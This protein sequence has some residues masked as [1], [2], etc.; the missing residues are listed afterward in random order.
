MAGSEDTSDTMRKVAMMPAL[1]DREKALRDVFVSEYLKDFDPLAAAMRCGFMRSFAEEYA[2]KFMDEPY[3]LQRI[4]ALQHIV[5][6]D[7]SGRD[8]S[9]AYNRQRVISALMREA[10][11]T[12][13]GSSAA[14][15]VAALS[16]LAV[17]YGL[18]EPQGKKEDQANP[19]SRG[20]VM[21]IPEIADV[22]Q[23]EEVALKTQQRLV[24]DV[25]S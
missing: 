4:Q 7:G 20:G 2:K 3:V 21:R 22:T 17:I 13:A 11:Y 8:D 9:L 6:E 10:H 16:R 14:A 5:S 15:R 24:S 23:W 25:R 18:N 1:S 19:N 12:G